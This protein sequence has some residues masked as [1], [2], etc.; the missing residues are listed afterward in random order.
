MSGLDL[1]DREPFAQCPL[2]EAVVT[3]FKD[4]PEGWNTQK[5]PESKALAWRSGYQLPSD[6]E[7]FG[8]LESMYIEAKAGRNEIVYRALEQFWEALWRIEKTSGA[9]FRS[10][11]SLVRPWPCGLRG[12]RMT[13]TMRGSS[14]Q[15]SM[16]CTRIVG[17]GSFWMSGELTKWLLGFLTRLTATAT[18]RTVAHDLNAPPLAPREFDSPQLGSTVVLGAG[19]TP[20][21]HRADLLGMPCVLRGFVVFTDCMF[22]RR[23][24]SYTMVKVFSMM[25]ESQLHGERRDVS[26]EGEAQDLDRRI[27]LLKEELAQESD[28]GGAKA[29]NMRNEIRVL[30]EKYQALCDALD[31]KEDG[32]L[33]T[34]LSDAVKKAPHFT[35]RDMAEHDASRTVAN[36]SSFTDKV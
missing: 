30:T 1:T 34:E 10:R 5:L 17:R 15:R 16:I 27:R 4:L 7:M 21:S 36:K 26:A 31:G 19:L 20:Q 25:K 18:T 2:V 28:K 23:K 32:T 33:E 12:S 35:V 14:L 9:C 11:A 29:L 6:A 8:I 13:Q 22:T 24:T 3:L